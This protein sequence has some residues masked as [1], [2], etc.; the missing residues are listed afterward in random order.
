[1][2]QNLAIL[3]GFKP[4]SEEEMQ[5]LRERVRP[6]AVDGRL[7]WYKTTKYFD[8]KVGREQHGY[9]TEQELPL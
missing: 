4:M 5:S 2:R 3:R 7:E 9:P 8:A 6:I 1:L